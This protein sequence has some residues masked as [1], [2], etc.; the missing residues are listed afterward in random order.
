MGIADRHYY[1]DQGQPTR[2]SFR[3][4]GFLSIRM[5][6]VNTW[7]IV[8]CIAVF[9]IDGFLPVRMWKP[10][11][12]SRDVPAAIE[13][14]Q[15]SRYQTIPLGN[16]GQ[17]RYFQRQIVDAGVNPAIPVGS[18]TYEWMPPLMRWLHF[19]TDVGFRKFEFW[20]LIGFQFLHANLTHLL[21]NMIGL[22]FFGP[23][24]EEYLGSKRYLAFYLLCGV[25]GALLYIILNLLG[26]V[27]RASLGEEV[28]IPGLLFSSTTTPL[29]GASAGIFG[30]L[31]AGAYLAPNAIVLLMFFLP[32]RLRTVAYALVAVA[33][34]TVFFRG[35]NAGGEAG[36]L[37]GAIAGFYFIRRPHHLHGF[38][39]FLGYA[40][41]TSHHYRHKGKYR[42][43]A[44]ARGE[45]ATSQLRPN[46]VE[47]DRILDKVYASGIDS[48]TETEKRTLREASE[49]G[50]Q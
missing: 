23:M 26:L 49:Q 25:C 11:E 7:L 42:A 38:F 22:Y 45:P 20:R 50:R 9:V 18:V 27:A 10:V 39:D 44:K 43:I 37:G 48:L 4:S 33:F 2:G 36:H 19:S 31:M 30:V 28:M 34:L 8:I 40:D 21:F 41:P 5:W 29:V 3:S 47:V 32:M 12:V 35:R 46:S 1:R 16:E 15:G 14:V 17:S 24:V 6:S 13:L